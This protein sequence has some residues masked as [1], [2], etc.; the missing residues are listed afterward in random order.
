MGK[1]LTWVWCKGVNSD[2]T[3]HHETKCSPMDGWMDG[4][5]YIVTNVAE[6]QLH[7]QNS[8]NQREPVQWNDCFR[9]IKRTNESLAVSMRCFARHKLHRTH[10]RTVLHV[11]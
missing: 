10:I 11:Q 9:T 3:T 5:M 8:L 7:W 6:F 4:C 2:V 1:H